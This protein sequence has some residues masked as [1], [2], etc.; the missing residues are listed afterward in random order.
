MASLQG[1]SLQSDLTDITLLSD[2]NTPSLPADDGHYCWE[3]CPRLSGCVWWIFGALLFIMTIQAAF[4][5]PYVRSAVTHGI[6][7][8]V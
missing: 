8:T 4:V 1:A 6:E 2:V 3:R 7:D 5:P